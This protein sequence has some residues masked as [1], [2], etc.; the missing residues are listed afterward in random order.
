MNAGPRRQSLIPALTSA[1]VENPVA[2]RA[3]LRKLA[4][5]QRSI[6]AR[7]PSA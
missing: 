5:S 3:R 2:I 6:R 1:D 4:Q 7:M